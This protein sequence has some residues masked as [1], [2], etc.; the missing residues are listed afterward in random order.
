M[1]G[2]K[3]EWSAWGSWGEVL[4]ISCQLYARKVKGES[5]AEELDGSQDGARIQNQ[6]V[7]VKT[8]GSCGNTIAKTEN[9]GTLRFE[10]DGFLG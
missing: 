2:E 5:N 10:L 6:G 7:I 4:D 3:E 1:G 8:E 9:S